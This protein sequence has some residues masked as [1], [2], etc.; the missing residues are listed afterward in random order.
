MSDR[1]IERAQ[2]LH[3]ELDAL[4]T[5]HDLSEPERA[6]LVQLERCGGWRPGSRPVR[7][8]PQIAAF[9]NLLDRAEQEELTDR[10]VVGGSLEEL[11]RV[12]RERLGSS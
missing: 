12:F 3:G 9:L 1:A 4:F 6:E 8:E 2:E 5:R 7:P 11:R 10:A